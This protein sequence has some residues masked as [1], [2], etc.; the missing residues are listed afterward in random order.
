[1]AWKDAATEHGLRRKWHRWKDSC[2]ATDPHRKAPETDE[3]T[4]FRVWWQIGRCQTLPLPRGEGLSQL[5]CLSASA[6]SRQQALWPVPSCANTCAPLVFLGA[7]VIHCGRN[8]SGILWS[9]KQEELPK[10]SSQVNKQ[11]WCTKISPMLA[12]EQESDVNTTEDVSQAQWWLPT[13]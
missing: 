9:Q 8:M 10:S 5:T 12:K 1:M 13:E 4:C 6:E 7:S 2:V 11:T 3:K